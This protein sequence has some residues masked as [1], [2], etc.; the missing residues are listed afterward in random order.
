MGNAPQKA[1]QSGMEALNLA[2]RN[3]ID[4]LLVE[5]KL[6]LGQILHLQGKNKEAQA[7]FEQSL[8]LATRSQYFSGICKA[9]MES[10]KLDYFFGNYDKS[11]ENFSRALKM[12]TDQGFLN[13]QAEA[14]NYIGKFYHTTGQFGKSVENYKKSIEILKKTSDSAHAA[15]VL[16]SIGKTYINEG[17]LHMALHCYLDAYKS[18]GKSKNYLALAEVCNHLGSIYL[19]MGQSDKSLDYHREALKYRVLLGNREGMAKS[20]N[21]LGETYYKS[22]MI[23]SAELH[24]QQSLECCLIMGYKK[25]TVKALTNLGKVNETMHHYQKASKFLLQAYNISI[26]AGYDAGAAES[27]LAMGNN[28]M[29]EWRYAE[30][31]KRYESSLAI[32]KSA[33]LEEMFRD[34]YHGL[35]RCYM[36]IQDSAGALRYHMLLSDAEM[37]KQ[38]AEND[39]QLSELRIIFETEKQEKAYEVLRKDNE[40]K[41]MTIKRKNAWIWMVI[42][43]LIFTLL[44]SILLFSRFNNKRKANRKLEELNNRILTQNK[45]LEKLNKELE[46]ANREK[47]KIFSIIGHELRN[48]L[49]WLQN[50]TEMLSLKYLTM[51][52][53]KVQKTLYSLDESAK[54]AFHLMDNLLHW[55]R[56][57]LNRITPKIS[58]QSLEK[59]ISESTRM[60]NTILEQKNINLTLQ[61]PE[62]SYIKVDPDL[63]SCVI[64]NLLSN[65]IKFTPTDGT[66]EITSIAERPNYLISVSDTG[67]GINQKKMKAIFDPDK[68]HSSPGLMNERGYG[69]G[70]KLCKE[71]V[72]ING[73]KIWI[74][75]SGTSGTCFSFTAPAS[76]KA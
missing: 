70:L 22:G 23:D 44:F 18:S 69:L 38:K 49:Y 56:S 15:S 71:F 64:R 75:D 2:N 73:G 21:N 27:S 47:D 66:I 36:A 74:S 67:I 13:V 4:T 14:Y 30:A 50:L 32:A 7:W 62:E 9:E 11:Y 5:S 61:L 24:L 68:N 28:L 25:G 53:E 26:K 1:Y 54:N 72:E 17:N 34:I 37:K 12:A 29:A 45:E 40:L 63:F 46:I 55:S 51:T 76:R 42:I 33:N 60:Y 58:E 8:V 19:I 43:A 52:A 20:H 59:L 3:R 41:E 35:F 48:P 65:A 39:Q 10:G 16:L 31:I 6:L 57:R